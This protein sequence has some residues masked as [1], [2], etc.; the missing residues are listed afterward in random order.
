MKITIGS[1]F[2]RLTVVSKTI[3][4]HIFNCANKYHLLS[5]LTKSCGCLKKENAVSNWNKQSLKKRK[6]YGF[7]NKNRIFKYYIMNHKGTHGIYVYN[8]IDLYNG[9]DRIDHKIGYIVS[10]IVPC[11]TTCMMKGKL[12][13]DD[14]FKII[15][16]I[17]NH[18]LA[19]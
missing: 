8:G 17:F 11:C 16:K 14:F 2:S 10:N 3:E 18:N 7:S 9:I 6:E 1:K 15:K 5:G 12:S 4:S 13:Y 19:G